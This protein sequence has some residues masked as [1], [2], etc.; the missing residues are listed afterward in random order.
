MNNRRVDHSTAGAHIATEKEHFRML[1]S[2][3]VDADRLDTEAFYLGLEGK[4][5]TRG[6]WP[7]EILGTLKEQVDNHLAG[8]SK[9]APTDVN[10]AHAEI[11]AAAREKA[12][13][14]KGLFSLTVPT[15]GGKTLSSLAFALEHAEAHKLDRII[16]VIPFTSIIEQTAAA[17]RCA[18]GPHLA[19][20]VVEHHSA[21]RELGEAERDE[22]ERQAGER[23]RLA[24]E[25]WDAP[26]IVTTAVQ[27]FESLFSNRPGRCRKLHN[28]A[29]SVVILDE[30][31]TLPLPL[32]RPCVAALDELARNYSASIVLCTATQPAL[33]AE[34]S[35]GSKGFG[36]GL[37]HVCEIAKGPSLAP[38][39][40]YE[41]LKRVTVKP[42]IELDDDALA[43]R[44]QQRERVLCIVGTRKHARELYQKLGKEPGTFHLSALMCPV[45]RSK[46]LREIKE[47]LK[48]GLCRVVA[49]TVI[50]AGV[51][52][53]FP[54]VYR[55]MAGLDSIAQAAGRCNREGKHS[56]EESIVQLFEAKDRAP[57]RELRKFEQA[58]R[59][60]LRNKAHADDP[61][62]LAAIEAYFNELY[63][64]QEAGRKD[65]LDEY[66]IAKS[67][68]CIITRDEISIPFADVA[69]QLRM[70]ET[71]ME[72]VIV[73][74]DNEARGLIEEL[75]N[76]E[77]VGD[78]ARKLQPY[79]VNVP[80][81]AY[82]E[83]RQLGRME[84]INQY[85]F[86]DQ[87]MALNKDGFTS[88]YHDEFGIDW[89]DA[90]FRN[91]ENGI[92]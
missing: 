56:P 39:D 17:F 4:T 80:R 2:T 13:E 46:K 38:R 73:P 53:D 42:P 21:Y 15:G 85:R 86:G 61:L 52:V 72:P 48:N 78:I 62:S 88:L 41:R 9:G 20:C 68:G 66:D 81:G 44:L 82:A 5:P 59:S 63:W 50:E 34:R 8:L 91:A 25:N 64:S 45:H 30:A 79:M 22:S 36:G 75:G 7:A 54:F 83:L 19:N 16:Y 89:S 33:L 12:R 60:V 6:N 18:I 29:K 24:T 14:R 65:G 77:R 55:A 90:T 35:D 69:Q 37:R 76:A 84:P 47:A 43:E 27:F 67:A 70:I 58:A 92:L 26:I 3:L 31:Q 23:T 10:R 40:L 28:I 11:L 74:Y 71:A 51:D 57:I 87:F 32:L 49:T 1:F